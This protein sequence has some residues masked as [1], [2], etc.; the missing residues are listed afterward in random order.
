[1]SEP[2]NG[3]AVSLRSTDICPQRPSGTLHRRNGPAYSRKTYRE[4]VQ[5]L[6]DPNW[7]VLQIS[8]SLRLSEHTVRAIRHREAR[9]IAERKKSLAAIL[10]NVAELGAG[11]MEETVGKVGCRDAAIATGIA[12]DK[13][14]ALTGQMPT[15]QIANIIMPSEEERA[16]RA[17]IDAK[18]D[19]IARRLRESSN[20][21]A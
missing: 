4:A 7:S 9:D 1:M 15:L 14:L 11:R 2:N 21:S 5:L 10:A 18:L 13:M 17:S 3:Q 16:E 6:A 20:P 12:V 19:A 8:K